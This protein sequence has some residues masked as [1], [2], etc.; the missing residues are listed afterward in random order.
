MDDDGGSEHVKLN[1]QI[2]KGS[3]MAAFFCER[4]RIEPAS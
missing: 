4:G 3:R 2:K 1:E